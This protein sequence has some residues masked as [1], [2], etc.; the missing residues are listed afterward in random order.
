MI[1]DE[2][3]VTVVTIATTK[4]KKNV[5]FFCL[6]TEYFTKKRMGIYVSK[7]DVD[8]KRFWVLQRGAYHKINLCNPA[9]YLD[10]STSIKKELH[11]KLLRIESD[12]GLNITFLNLMKQ[13]L[14][15]Y[16]KKT[17]YQN[18]PKIKYNNNKYNNNKY[19]NLNN[20]NQL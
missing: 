5:C 6:Y 7:I 13:K 12:A 15:Q 1:D 18:L 10:V 19:N 2:L 11:W 8:D 14:N 17:K 20:N 16:I 9:T 3:N 4:K